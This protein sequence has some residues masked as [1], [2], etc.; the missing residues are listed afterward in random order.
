MTLTKSD[1]KQIR[2]ILKEELDNQEEKFEAKITK[3]KSEFIEKIDPI[4][5]E[6]STAREE[7]PLIVNR[8]EAF[9]EVY[10]DGK[11]I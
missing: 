1:F 5:N 10:P 6:V 8:L 3:V 9:E 2:I 11:H 7:R 4:L